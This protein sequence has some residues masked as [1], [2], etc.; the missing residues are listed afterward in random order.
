MSGLGCG[1]VVLLVYALG[2]TTVEQEP[3]EQVI[4]RL[5]FSLTKGAPMT[6]NAE[7]LEAMRDE[8]TGRERVVFRGDV[9]VLQGDLR[10]DCD[11]LEILYPG[12]SGGKA[13]RVN[14][15]GSVRIKQFGNELRCTEAVMDNEAC[16]AECI[17][18]E[19]PASLRRGE[20]IV[21][22]EKILIDLCKGILKVRGAKVQFGPQ[23]ENP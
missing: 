4:N 16:T 15:R 14:A 22:G 11:W 17:S 12:G 9:E 18:A 21:E 10:V 8:K 3:S 5:G 20:E 19:G 6:I 23:E 7:E 13:S 1:L 2:G